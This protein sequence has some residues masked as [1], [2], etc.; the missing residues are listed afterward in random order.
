MGAFSSIHNITAQK[1]RLFMK[2]YLTFLL[3]K[4]GGACLAQEQLYF[5]KYGE[6]KRI[7]LAA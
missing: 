1:N 3:S 7:Q 5:N 2:D 4:T 6:L